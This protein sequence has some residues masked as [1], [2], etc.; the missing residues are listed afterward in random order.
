MEKT[1]KKSNK[2]VA[3]KWLRIIH[4]DLGF[5]MVGIC[6]IY[7]ISGILLNHMDGKDPAYKTVEETLQFDPGLTID[8]LTNKWSASENLPELKRILKEGDEHYSLML[9]GGIGLYNKESGQISYE[10]HRQ[11]P[12]IYWIN[13][14]H[15]NKVNGWTPMA[16]IFAISLIFLAVSGLFITSRKKGVRG[17]GKWYL[18]AGI[19]IPVVYILIAI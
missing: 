14:L 16:D 19:L 9:N 3:I 13:K 6:L 18:I 10:H 1:S 8:Q 15:Y 5:L 12:F 11:R 2:S 4:R 17:T 7:A